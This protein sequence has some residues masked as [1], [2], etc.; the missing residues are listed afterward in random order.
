MKAMKGEVIFS[1]DGT[2][3]RLAKI[4]KNKDLGLSLS[5]DR[6]GPGDPPQTAAKDK[7]ARFK[8]GPQDAPDVPKADTE[9]KEPPLKKALKKKTPATPAEKPGGDDEPTDKG[10]DREGKNSARRH[11]R[12][13]M[14]DGRQG[15]CA[16]GMPKGS[17]SLFRSGVS[18]IPW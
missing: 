16:G 9:H 10:G 4:K 1:D 18:W 15:A 5:S 14:Q 2:R 17:L 12:M 8:S 13:W 7:K 11:W 6:T 3:I